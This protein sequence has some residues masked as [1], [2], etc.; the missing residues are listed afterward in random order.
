MFGLT[1]KFTFTSPNNKW[2]GGKRNTWTEISIYR[3]HRINKIE[4]RYHITKWITAMS[5]RNQVRG[6]TGKQIWWFLSLIY[7]NLCIKCYINIVN[8]FMPWSVKH[9]HIQITSGYQIYWFIAPIMYYD[10]SQIFRFDQ[11]KVLSLSM[12]SKIMIYILLRL[13]WLYVPHSMK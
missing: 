13:I 2:F 9:L 11:F 5:Y 10:L 4:N 12:I 6:W 8:D 1:T 7:A 3:W